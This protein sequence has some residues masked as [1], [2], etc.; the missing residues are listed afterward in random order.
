MNI[1][2]KLLR[3]LF[4]NPVLIVPKGNLFWLLQFSSFLV[5]SAA[6]TCQGRPKADLVRACNEDKGW[7]DVAH[8]T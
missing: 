4:Y 6:S 5:P 7:A 8:E 1:D 2:F 3:V